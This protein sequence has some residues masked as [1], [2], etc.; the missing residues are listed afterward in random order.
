MTRIHSH[1]RGKSHSTQPTSRRPLSWVTY[2]PDEITTLIVKLAK[3]GYTPSAIGIKLRDEYNIPLVQPVIGKGIVEVLA[4]NGVKIS[5]PEELERL[6]SKAKKLQTHL[7]SHKADHTNVRSLELV[8]AKIHRLSKYYKRKD[9]LPL[10]WKYSA[11][12][13]QLA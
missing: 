11:V 6:L 2:S 4:E 7:K 5:L 12:I 1:R 8:E 13:A 9:I 3:D 10:N